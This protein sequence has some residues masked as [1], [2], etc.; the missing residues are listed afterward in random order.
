[1]AEG[2]RGAARIRPR[3]LAQQLH[4]DLQQRARDEQEN[5]GEQNC[6]IEVHLARGFFGHLLDASLT[7]LHEKACTL[8]DSGVSGF[9][10]T[11]AQSVSGYV[12]QPSRGRIRV[13]VEALAM[14]YLVL[15]CRETRLANGHQSASSTGSEVLGHDGE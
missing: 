12:S 13:V 15:D 2:A 3:A 1:M 6:L 7:L 5:D 11:W 8:A 9:V 10:P 14:C 4:H